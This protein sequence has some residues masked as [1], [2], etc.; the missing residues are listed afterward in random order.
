MQEERS[1]HKVIAIRCRFRCLMPDCAKGFI[2]FLQNKA[3]AMSVLYSKLYFFSHLYCNLWLK[4]K[5]LAHPP[6]ILSQ[7]FTR[8]FCI[9]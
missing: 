2:F 8:L 3:K 5:Y 1:Q 7:S 9:F 4:A 6:Q